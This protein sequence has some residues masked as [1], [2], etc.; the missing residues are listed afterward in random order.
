MKISMKYANKLYKLDPKPKDLVADKLK[1]DIEFRRAE[2]VFVA[3][4]LEDLRF[5]VKG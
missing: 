4:N 3:I 5:G 1:K 2:L